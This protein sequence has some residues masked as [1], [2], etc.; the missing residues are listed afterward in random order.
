[1]LQATPRDMMQTL[2]A[3]GRPGRPLFCPAVYEHKARLIDQAPSDVAADVDLLVEATRAEYETYHPDLLTVGIDV[4]NIEPEALGCVVEYPA[5]RDAVPAI[6]HPCIERAGQIATLAV[7]NPQSAGRMPLIL[8]ATRRVHELLG[9]EV[10][11]R[12]AISGPFSIACKVMGIEAMLVEGFSNPEG[13]EPVMRFCTDVA[14][15]FGQALLQRGVEVCVFD[16]HAAPPLVSP[17][18]FRSLIL[19]HTKR[20][21]EDLTRHGARCIEYVIGGDTSPMANDLAASGARI[22]LADYK[23]DLAPFAH[24][25]SQSDILVRRNL[26]PNLIEAGNVQAWTEQLRPAVALA[27]ASPRCILGTGV[28]SYNT[29]IEHL[30]A[31]RRAYMELASAHGDTCP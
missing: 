5:G 25:L 7:P 22:I 6:E 28:I 21:M 31:V 15:S 16:S 4:Y 29:P 10:F 2:L 27:K 11:V 17:D 18:M 19:P 20:L 26:D 14:L 8:E 3:G 13:V 1:M 23:A 24:E 30:Q 12:G 9:R